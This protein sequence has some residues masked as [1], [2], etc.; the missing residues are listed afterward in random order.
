MTVSLDWWGWYREILDGLAVAVADADVEWATD[1]DG[2]PWIILG[3]KRQSGIG[4][5]HAMVLEFRKQRDNDES[6]RRNELIRIASTVAVFGKSDPQEP[7]RNLRH[8]VERM[9]H[10][11][12][13]LYDDRSLNES[14]SNLN[15]VTADAF[16]LESNIGRETVGQIEIRI[17]KPAP[18]PDY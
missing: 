10:V 17:T 5:P 15:I 11:E 18:Q 13:N 12:T 8:T 2:N 16:E 1:G 7:E 14:I 4:H 6:S 3:Q 9:A